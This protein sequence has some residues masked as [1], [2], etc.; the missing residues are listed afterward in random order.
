M[1]PH[2]PTHSTAPHL[3][4]CHLLAGAKPIPQVLLMGLIGYQREGTKKQAVHLHRG[5]ERGCRACQ[6]WRHPFAQQRPSM[7]W[8]GRMSPGQAPANSHPVGLVVRAQSGSGCAHS[9]G[10]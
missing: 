7:G 5:Q 6:E 1:S 4:L 10:Q 8:Q 9:L 2:V 3:Q